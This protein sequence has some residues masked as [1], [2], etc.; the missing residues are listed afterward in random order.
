MSMKSHGRLTQMKIVLFHSALGLRH[1]ENALASA[2]R[3]DG[4]DVTVPDLYDGEV[5]NTLHEGLAL[6]DTV[7][8]TVIRD[9]ARQALRD[10]PAETVLAGVSMGTGVVS[11]IWKDRPATPAVLL[12][13]GYADLPDQVTAGVRV[14]LH[15]AVGDRFVPDDILAR[16]QDA[17][18]TRGIEAHVHQYADVGHFFTDSTS[19]DYDAAAAATLFGQVRQFLRA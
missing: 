8:W 1:V 9:R 14:S 12:I 5:V 17:A 6:K 7:G 18:A 19:A 10:L 4:H 16:W 2:L 11:E 15:T 13:H 3:D